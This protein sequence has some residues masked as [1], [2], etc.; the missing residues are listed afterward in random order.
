MFNSSAPSLADIAAVTGNDRNGW[1]NGD[2]WWIL[3]ILFALFGGWGNG[4]NGNGCGCASKNT[5]DVIDATLQRGFDNQ[6]VMSKLNGIE[7]GICSLGYDQ[8][9]QINQINTNIM[10]TGYGI[11]NAIQAN[12]IA[13]MQQS[14]ALQAQLADCCCENRAAIAQ[15]RYD[16]AT[17]TCAVT[18]AIQQAA[19][20]IT[21]NANANYRSLH[22]EMVASQM[23][24]KN[25]RIAE[26]QSQVQA[27]NL[28]QSQSNQNQYL[29]N[30][31]RPSAIPAFQ[32]P[33]PYAGYGYGY[34][35]SNQC[36]CN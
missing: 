2:G 22:D 31:L 18:N 30:T 16:M 20:D 27:L 23:E 36:C 11:T 25:D 1:G 5:T 29:I 13:S 33:N 15:V 35:N 26:L 24:A 7:Q 17:D 3:I 9:A 4:F 32:V 8:L 19:R 34:C 12:S 10:Q 28:A 21:D 14:N 6:G